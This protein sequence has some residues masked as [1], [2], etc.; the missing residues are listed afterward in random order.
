VIVILA[1]DRIT[2]LPWVPIAFTQSVIPI[3]ALL[4]ALAELLTLPERWREALT[5]GPTHE[6]EG[7]AL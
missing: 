1:G 6:H 4:I 5:G 7:T 2:S 3:G